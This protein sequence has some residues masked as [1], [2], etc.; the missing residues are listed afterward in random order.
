MKPRMERLYNLLRL[1]TEV[2]LTIPTEI[3]EIH[4]DKD[5]LQESIKYLMEDAGLETVKTVG[6]EDTIINVKVIQ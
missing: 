2:T 1:S 3:L 6:S 4:R 5:K